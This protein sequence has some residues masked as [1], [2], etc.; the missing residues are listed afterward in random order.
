MRRL[1]LLGIALLISCQVYADSPYAFTP[2]EKQ[3][4]QEHPV[5]R[6]AIDSYWPLEYIENGEHKGLTRDYL[7]QIS[8]ISGLQFELVP[9][10]N[11][12]ETLALIDAGKI[13][14]TTAVSKALIDKD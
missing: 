8:R 6:Y 4:I 11:W 1:M 14:L 3:W 12:S 7:Q 13:D 9:T 2:A 10:K 5:V